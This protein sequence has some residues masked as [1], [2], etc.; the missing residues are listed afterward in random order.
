M[1][2]EGRY[3]LK[4]AAS[5]LRGAVSVA[6]SPFKR[7]AAVRAQSEFKVAPFGMRHLGIRAEISD[8]DTFTKHATPT[9]TRHATATVT[10][11]TCTGFIVTIPSSKADQVTSV[12]HFVIAVCVTVAENSKLYLAPLLLHSLLRFLLLCLLFR[13]AF[14]QQRRVQMQA[15]ADHARTSHD[16]SRST[17]V[18][19]HQVADEQRR[20][21]PGHS[22][23]QSKRAAHT[24]EI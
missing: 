8:Q 18:T 3:G 4:C 22:V 7:F 23:D 11:V 1:A 5:K 10:K 9:L 21:Q 16:H 19:D 15:R 24:E 20:G 12:G 2:G 17:V 14:G 13:S 6:V